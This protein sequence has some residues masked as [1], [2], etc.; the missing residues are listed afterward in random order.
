MKRT[1]QISQLE[2][3]SPVSCPIS[4]WPF[5]IAFVDLGH[6]IIVQNTLFKTYEGER[7]ILLAV[8]S[9]FYSPA[10]YGFIKELVGQDT[11]S[12][13]NEIVQ[14]TVTTAIL[15]G[16][17][18]FSEL[19]EAFLA[20]QAFTTTGEIMK[21]VAP[22]GWFLVGFSLLE[23]AFAYRLPQKRPRLAAMH[24]DWRAYRTGGY[25]MEN[26]GVAYRDRGIRISILGLAGFWSIAQV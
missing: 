25:L 12:A 15:V 23:L 3:A 26:L 7:Q 8:Q 11:L 5:S 10:K 4:R 21:L 18:F 13:A 6:K 14:A 19:F 24:F 16:I 20:E 9:A 17:L 1:R 22:A 2:F